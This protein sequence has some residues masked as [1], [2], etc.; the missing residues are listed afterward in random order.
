MPRTPH[1]LVKRM[2]TWAAQIRPL[3]VDPSAITLY[4]THIL[5]P[6]TALRRAMRARSILSPM[7]FRW[8]GHGSGRTSIRPIIYII[9][10]NYKR[11][12][13]RPMLSHHRNRG[14][15]TSEEALPN[16]LSR[17]EVM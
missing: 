9:I 14:R 3:P 10:N 12:A 11:A 2:S 5:L 15:N 7:V 8:I 16:N 6:A 1:K 13:I 4:S 17:M